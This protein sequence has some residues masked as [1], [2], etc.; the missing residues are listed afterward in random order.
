MVGAAAA[1]AVIAAIGVR[2]LT[3]GHRTRDNDF[4]VHG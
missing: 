2:S 4:T 3:H 1:T